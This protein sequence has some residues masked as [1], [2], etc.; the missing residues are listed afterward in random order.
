MSYEDRNF[1]EQTTAEGYYIDVDHGVKLHSVT[2]CY[3][4]FLIFFLYYQNHTIGVCFSIFVH[5][6]R[7]MLNFKIVDTE[8][9]GGVR[10][11]VVLSDI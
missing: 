11:G 1:Q 5:P 4:V 9:S 3:N 10:A 7:G 2:L 8:G 6:F